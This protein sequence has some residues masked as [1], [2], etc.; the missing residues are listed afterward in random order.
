MTHLAKVLL[1]GLAQ[2]ARP[3]TS[4]P[5]TQVV[6]KD[7]MDMLVR[8]LKDELEARSESKTGLTRRGCAAGCTARSCVIIWT[9]RSSLDV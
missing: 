6:D 7:L 2:D 4:F 1:Y 8:E 3:S 9:P 5:T